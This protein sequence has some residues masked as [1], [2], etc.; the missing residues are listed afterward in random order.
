MDY[1]NFLKDFPERCE[2]ILVNYS[3]Q[4]AANDLEVTLMLT[5]ATAGFV[6]VF[7]N[8]RDGNTLTSN[9]LQQYPNASKEFDALL[10]ERFLTSGK[11]K[12][13]GKW[14]LAEK[15]LSKI[16]PWTKGNLEGNYPLDPTKSMFYI[17]DLLRNALAH[18][19]IRT[20]PDE[21]NQIKTLIFIV[22]SRTYSEKEDIKKSKMKYDKTKYDM[23]ATSPKGFCKL[24]VNW[25]TFLK[26]LD[27]FK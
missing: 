16:P 19:N 3:D 18:G 23:L 10:S 9:P 21:N 27:F 4:A 22:W 17:L 8:F 26:G 1:N 12:I 15:H 25:L 2:K 20:H 24:L 6:T 14:E 11:L 5:I 13:T 7:E